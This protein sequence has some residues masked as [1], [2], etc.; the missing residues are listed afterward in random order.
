LTPLLRG[1]LAL[2]FCPYLGGHGVHDVLSLIEDLGDLLGVPRG[3][4]FDR[5]LDEA[6]VLPPDIGVTPLVPG[7]IL[8]ASPWCL[9]SQIELA[10]TRDLTGRIC[11]ALEVLALFSH[12][13]EHISLHHRGTGVCSTR[14]DISADTA[15]FQLDQG[16]SAGSGDFS[17]HSGFQPTEPSIWSSMSRLHSTAYSI[18]RVRVIGSMK[19]FTTM[20][21]AW[22]SE[23]PRLI[24]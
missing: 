14:P 20:L 2:G 17:R 8:R 7:T 18:G 23:R 6:S 3:L 15:A 16:L 19:P 21:I 5:R 11:A 10:E 4:F 22:L 1:L 13:H 12:R 9:G 24:R